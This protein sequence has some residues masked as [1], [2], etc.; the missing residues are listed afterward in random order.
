MYRQT[1]PR[2]IARGVA[3]VEFAVLLPPVV[4]IILGAIE[5]ARAFAVQHALQEAS[6][7]GCRIYALGDKTQQEAVDMIDLSLA[8]SG[9]IGYSI[10]FAPALKDDIDHNLEPVAV[11]I[12]IP[13]HKVGFGL[14][15]ALAGSTIAATSVLPADLLGADTTLNSSP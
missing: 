12:S 1:T 8:D 15:G 2:I 3:A 14:G 7:N 6:T 11:T 13:F 4:L 10:Q 5:A 9:F